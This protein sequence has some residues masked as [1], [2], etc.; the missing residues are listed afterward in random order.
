MNIKLLWWSNNLPLLIPFVLVEECWWL[1]RPTWRGAKA[2]A[3]AAVEALTVGEAWGA[4]FERPHTLLQNLVSS[5]C[6]RSSN[7]SENYHIGIISSQQEKCCLSIQVTIKNK[8]CRLKKIKRLSKTK[9]ERARP[10]PILRP[11]KYTQKKI[12]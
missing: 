4:V 7:Y 9:L 10:R 8:R 11:T 3:R 12:N 6:K 1:S 5:Y 2:D